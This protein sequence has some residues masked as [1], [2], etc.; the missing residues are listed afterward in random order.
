MILQTADPMKPYM[1]F[2]KV[3]A[4]TCKMMNALII[5]ERNKTGCRRSSWVSKLK[6]KKIFPVAQIFFFILKLSKCQTQDYD[7]F[8]LAT[9]LILESLQLKYYGLISTETQ[10]IPDKN[11]CF[12]PYSVITLNKL[13]R[14]ECLQRVIHLKIIQELKQ[15]E[16]FP[17]WR[18]LSL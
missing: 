10:V 14:L 15:E 6:I 1:V 13:G 8:E 18:C 12:L 2:S 4:C 17:F 11:T 3:L 16:L 9:I 7:H 5:W